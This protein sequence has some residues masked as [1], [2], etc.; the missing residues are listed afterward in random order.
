MINTEKE[1]I[2]KNHYEEYTYYIRSNVKYVLFDNFFFALRLK[3]Y[4]LQPRQAK[5]ESNKPLDL[6]FLQQR[7][8]RA[9][10]DSLRCYKTRGWYSKSAR[11]GMNKNDITERKQFAAGTCNYVGESSR[12][13]MTRQ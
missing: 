3:K 8:R 2:M 1:N 4:F 7:A 6:V 11:L 5:S 9:R 10:V 12:S 13:G